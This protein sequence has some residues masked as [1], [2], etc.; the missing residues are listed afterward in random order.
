MSGNAANGFYTTAAGC[1]SIANF[2]YLALLDALRPAILQ[3]KKQSQAKFEKGISG[4][5]SLIIF[6]TLAQSIFTI[7]FA[8]PIV[9]L[10]YGEGYLQAVPVLRIEAWILTFSYIGSVRDIWILAEEK[11]HFLWIINLGGVMVN[12]LLNSLLIPVWGAS[13]AAAATV[14]TQFAANVVMG[15]LIKPMRQSMHLM[16]KGVNPKTMLNLLEKR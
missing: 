4:L 5:Y 15:F 14:I 6:V 7:L 3:S 1:V 16:L 2:V 9:L 12:I 10:L 8:R 11:H 13:G